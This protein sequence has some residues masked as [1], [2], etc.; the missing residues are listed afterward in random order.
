MFTPVIEKSRDSLLND[1]VDLNE[2]KLSALEEIGEA[3]SLSLT[4]LAHLIPLILS[5]IGIDLDN[6]TPADFTNQQVKLEPGTCPAP[7]NPATDVEGIQEVLGRGATIEEINIVYSDNVGDGISETQKT[8]LEHELN[9]TFLQDAESD[10]LDKW[11]EVCRATGG[12]HVLRC[13]G[14][15]I[16]G[17]YYPKQVV[18]IWGLTCVNC[19]LGLRVGYEVPVP[20]TH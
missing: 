11:G 4:D 17:P 19:E 20:T 3:L 6:D 7:A 13:D 8:A 12:P 16:K 5:G 10:F 9:T 1:A 2:N 14:T 15:V 18:A